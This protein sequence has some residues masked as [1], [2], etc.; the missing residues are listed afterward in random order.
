[1]VNIFSRWDAE[2]YLDIA[3]NGYRYQSDRGRNSST[4]FYPMYPSLIAATAFLTGASSDAGIL[5]AG[6]L[7]SNLALLVGLVFL[8]KLVRMDFD[9]ETAAR[10]ALYFLVFPSTFFFSAVY[11]ES[12]FFA[13][14]VIAFYAARRQLWWVAGISGAA[15][16]LTRPPGVLMFVALGFEYL[17]QRKFKLKEIRADAAAL[18]LVPLALVAH[19]GYMQWRFGSFWIFLHTEKEWGRDLVGTPGRWASFAHFSGG[20]LLIGVLA[21]GLILVGWKRLR[22]SYGIFATLA[23]LMPMASGTLL[24]MGRFC[25]ILFP[26]YIVLALIGKNP[27][28]DRNWL[29]L[30]SSMAVLFM[31]MFSLWR[32][33]G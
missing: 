24:G 10:S 17:Y 13:A 4:A 31:A 1:M 28:L 32:Y 11:T 3:K 33:V 15:A 27:A 19:F 29:I 14:V 21:L 7:I 20:D 25:A 9:E 18:L 5:A 23:F 26:I 22:P 30:S 16:T 8:T 6:L 2:W 12:L